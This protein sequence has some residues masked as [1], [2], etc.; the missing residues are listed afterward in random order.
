MYYEDCVFHYLI[1]IYDEIYD[2]CDLCVHTCY[3]AYGE[4]CGDME[5][6]E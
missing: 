6:D 3:A 2:W 1:Q 5:E 4:H